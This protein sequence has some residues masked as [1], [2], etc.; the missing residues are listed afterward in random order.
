MLLWASLISIMRV[1]V[2]GMLIYPLAGRAQKQ[3]LLRQTR[4]HTH[5]VSLKVRKAVSDRVDQDKDIQVLAV[6]RVGIEPEL[7]I[8]I[9]LVSKRDI[10]KKLSKDLDTTVDGILEKTSWFELPFLKERSTII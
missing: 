1:L 7:G 4:P 10:P 8:N 5:P 3:A 9:V 2:T 6:A